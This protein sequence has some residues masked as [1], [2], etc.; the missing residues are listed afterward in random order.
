MSDVST[1]ACLEACAY[2]V[3]ISSYN[4]YA[5]GFSYRIVNN[6]Y[7]AHL[8][9]SMLYENHCKYLRKRVMYS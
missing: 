2:T 9:L 1:S 3:D 5:Y 6:V 4:V 7:I 8:L